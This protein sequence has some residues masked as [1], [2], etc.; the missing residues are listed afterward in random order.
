MNSVQIAELWE[1]AKIALYFFIALK[2]NPDIKET[3][4]EERKHFYE[5]DDRFDAGAGTGAFPAD[6]LRRFFQV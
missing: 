4:K 2:Y 5:K 6:R 1:N 3:H